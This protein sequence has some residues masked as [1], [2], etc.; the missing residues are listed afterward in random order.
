MDCPVTKTLDA[1]FGK[2]T[3][4]TYKEGDIIL[5][6]E[7]A[8]RGVLYLKK[9][10]VRQFTVSRSGRV[11][12]FHI[13]KPGSFFPMSWVFN[14]EPNRYYLDTVTPVEIYR[15]P[16][17]AVMK[18]L[19][20]NPLVVYDLARRLLLGLCGFRFHI[21]QLVMGTAYTKTVFVLL[22]LARMVSKHTMS[23][24]V[25]PVP[26]THQEIASWIGTT[27]E[28]VS[29]QVALLKKLGLIRCCRRQLVIPSIRRLEK[30]I[31]G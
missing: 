26:V 31:E 14:N 18:F 1:F 12:I 10:Y 15:A 30:E 21:E 19:H 7:D 23:P 27:R 6:A 2:F 4:L 9:G 24:V 20:D 22:H 16:K 5:Q 11:F 25:F 28:T 17:E 29:V 8:P 3:R 13:F